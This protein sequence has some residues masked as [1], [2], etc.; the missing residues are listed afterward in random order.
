M[1]GPGA[2]KRSQITPTRP[3]SGKKKSNIGAARRVEISDCRLATIGCWSVR[4]QREA[5]QQPYRKISQVWGL[6]CCHRQM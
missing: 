3:R 1:N 6:A 4:L 2:M 5:E